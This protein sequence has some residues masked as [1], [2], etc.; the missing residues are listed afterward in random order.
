LED[1]IDWRIGTSLAQHSNVFGDQ[2]FK[3]HFVPFNYFAALSIQP[4]SAFKDSRCRHL[5][6]AQQRLK[7]AKR[8]LNTERSEMLESFVTRYASLFQSTVDSGQSAVNSRKS[9]D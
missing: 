2:K 8:L 9:I 1:W 5:N 6:A 7:A 3:R 4:P